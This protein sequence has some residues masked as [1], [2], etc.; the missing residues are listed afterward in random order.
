VSTSLQTA[1]RKGGSLRIEEEELVLEQMTSVEKGVFPWLFLW[2][3][4]VLV[5]DFCLRRK[6]YVACI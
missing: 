5:L 4:G 2:P 6:W 3:G 1:R